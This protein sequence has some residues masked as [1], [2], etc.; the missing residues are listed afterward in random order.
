MCSGEVKTSDFDLD[1]F[2][3]L[4]FIGGNAAL[5]SRKTGLLAR[6]SAH[7]ENCLKFTLL[8]AAPQIHAFSHT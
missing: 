1:Q 5:E 6:L 4:S 8:N 3:G 2:T 7:T